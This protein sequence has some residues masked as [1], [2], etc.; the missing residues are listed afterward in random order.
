MARIKGTNLS[1]VR[2][3]VAKELGEDALARLSAALPPESR[4]AF[5]SFALTGWYPAQVY[6]DVLH[7]LDR[8]LG[9]G[10]G[11]LLRRGGA[12]A[13]EYDITRIHRV[14]FRLAN[15]AFV[16]EKSMDIWSRFF[17]TG[18]W[19]IRRPTPTSADGVLDGWSLTDAVTCEY[20]RAYLERMFLIVGAK[21]PQVRHIECRARASAHC[22]FLITWT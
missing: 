5:E 10:D 6:V 13:A 8:A 22:R 15:P 1:H 12:Y 17:D 18:E 21:Y 16:L 7:T 19:K 20:L 11:D 14:L 4:S 3:F 2:D 9:K